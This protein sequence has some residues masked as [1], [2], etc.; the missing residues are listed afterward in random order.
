MKRTPTTQTT[1]D[2]T[3]TLFVGEAEDLADTLSF[4][5]AW[6]RTASDKTLQDLAE[7]INPNAHPGALRD[8][9]DVFIIAVGLHV[10]ALRQRIKQVSQ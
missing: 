3:I 8:V 2:P 7:H 10:V 1:D 6:L 5:D 4:V 9:A